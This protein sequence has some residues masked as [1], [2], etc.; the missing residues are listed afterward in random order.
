MNFF[1]TNREITKS[2]HGTF[3]SQF[4]AVTYALSQ[5]IIKT[6]ILEKLDLDKTLNAIWRLFDMGTHVEVVHC[7][8][9]GLQPAL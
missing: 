8:S 2:A 7:D 4:W 6:Y 5:L 1:K 9:Y 3:P